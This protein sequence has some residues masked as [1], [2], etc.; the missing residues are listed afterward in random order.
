[1]SP[2]RPREQR[3]LLV[4]RIHWWIYPVSLALI[5]ALFFGAAYGYLHYLFGLL[6]FFLFIFWL[7]SLGFALYARLARRKDK[8]S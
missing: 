6:G 5:L 1:V 7:S 8:R 3:E 2:A 4:R